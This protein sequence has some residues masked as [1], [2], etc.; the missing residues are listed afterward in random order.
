MTRRSTTASAVIVLVLAASACAPAHERE[1]AAQAVRAF[2]AAVDAGDGEAACAV[3]APG[4][5]D[6]VEQDAGVPCADAVTSGDLGDELAARA[7]VE[8]VTVQRA[9]GQAQAR[10]TDDTVFLAAS[11]D[12]WVV[13]AAACDPQPPRPYDCALEE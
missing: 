12:A 2:Y 8:D 3:L 10:T 13:T 4:V 7:S 11:G 5:V 9:G 1:A 6:T